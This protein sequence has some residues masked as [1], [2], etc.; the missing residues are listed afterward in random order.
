MVYVFSDAEVSFHISIRH[1]PK[2]KINWR[3]SVTFQIKLHVK[4]KVI[5]NNIKNTLGIGIITVHT[6]DTAN[7]NVNSIK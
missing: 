6:K 2:Y 3:I 7:F 1:D 4:E 5:L